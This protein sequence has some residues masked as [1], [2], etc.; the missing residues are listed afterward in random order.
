M[1]ETQQA[2]PKV[3]K[4]VSLSVVTAGNTALCTAGR[5]VNHLH[6]RRSDILDV[7]AHYEF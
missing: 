3:K 2:Q 7:A 4:S 5:S 6:S 1:S